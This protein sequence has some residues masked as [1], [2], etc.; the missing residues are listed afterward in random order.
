MSLVEQRRHLEKLLEI[1]KQQLE[2]KDE[3]MQE[4]TRYVSLLESRIPE[5]AAQVQNEKQGDERAAEV[6]E[7]SDSDESDAEP[8]HAQHRDAP[9][10]YPPRTARPRRQVYVEI[11]VTNCNKTTAKTRP[12]PSRHSAGNGVPSAS[13]GDLSRPRPSKDSSLS[14][15]LGRKVLREAFVFSLCLD[16][17]AALR[18]IPT[19][20]SFLRRHFHWR[21][22]TSERPSSDKNFLFL[23]EGSQALA[24]KQPGEAGFYLSMRPKDPAWPSV[25]KLFV[26]SA[27]HGLNYYLG[28]YKLM[29]LPNPRLSQKQWLALSHATQDKWIQRIVSSKVPFVQRMRVRI[30]LR[31]SRREEPTE[32]EIDRALQIT[33]REESMWHAIRRAFDTGKEN[34]YA[35]GM[36][37]VGYDIAFVELVRAR[38]EMEDAVRAQR[39]DIDAGLEDPDAP[40]SSSGTNHKRKRPEH[41]LDGDSEDDSD[42]MPTH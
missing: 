14:I 28:Q 25:E 15:V 31:D 34:L 10:K 35:W 19:S 21:I 18:C 2:L 7:I 20:K 33:E 39:G 27:T 38:M 24:P 9:R 3:E 11:P 23:H 41:S 36:Q 26:A 4:L 42:Y 12:N 6:I 16:I 32:E 22:T 8:A 13:L 30:A 1:R 40:S 29:D 5:P 37:C 17:P